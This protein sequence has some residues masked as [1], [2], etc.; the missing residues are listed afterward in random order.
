LGLG[1][2]VPVGF[3]WIGLMS[4]ITATVALKLQEARREKN[5]GTQDEIA[6]AARLNQISILHWL[7]KNPGLSPGQARLD[8]LLGAKELHLMHKKRREMGD[9]S[10]GLN[11]FGYNEHVALESPYASLKW[12][13]PALAQIERHRANPPQM[14]SALAL[15]G[16]CM[17][18]QIDPEW[19]V[20]Y[21][22]P[23]KVVRSLSAAT[24]EN[25]YWDTYYW[26]IFR[27]YDRWVKRNEEEGGDSREGIAHF[28]LGGQMVRAS[29]FAYQLYAGRGGFGMLWELFGPDGQMRPKETY[30][31]PE[32]AGSNRG[33]FIGNGV[34]D[35]KLGSELEKSPLV[36]GLLDMLTFE[37][38]PSRQG[39]ADEP[40]GEGD[41]KPEHVV[42]ARSREEAARKVADANQG[43]G[44]TVAYEWVLPPGLRSL[45]IQRMDQRR[46][47]MERLT[48]AL[49]LSL[50][51][52]QA[53]N[54]E[55]EIGRS[56]VS[57]RAD[58]YDGKVLVE[59]KVGGAFNIRLYLGEM[60]LNER[61][62]GDKVLKKYLVIY[63][64]EAAEE[65]HTE[66]A[67]AMGEAV[68][69]TVTFA[70]SAGQALMA[71]EDAIA[72]R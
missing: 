28:K 12:G 58:Y 70:K 66:R 1:A 16:V 45:K 72:G 56:G 43:S 23:I 32:P 59:V 26:R 20:D 33:E 48:Q 65:R 2:D 14:P 36:H 47:L 52:S 38:E 8:S 51:P 22:A 42:V 54:F 37:D 69:V 34:S 57:R 62:A 67:I 50:D 5:M 11:P 31:E 44:K 53:N 19:V 41:S 35:Q 9:P 39:E 30:F 4:R 24:D 7:D 29:T 55:A 60:L 18:L 13:R 25:G 40:A 27:A 46:Q 6:H 17:A 3:D 68:G 71:M 64:P 21:E 61:L 49:Q 10:P 15:L 63:N